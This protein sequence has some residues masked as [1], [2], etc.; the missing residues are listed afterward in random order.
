VITRRR[1]PTYPATPAGQARRLRDSED[2]YLAGLGHDMTWRVG[3]GARWLK[4]DPGYRGT[5]GLCGGVARLAWLGD[6]VGYH[7]YEGA[8]AKKMFSGPRKC[9]RGR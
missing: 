6:G 5:C 3:H 9:T 7:G 1:K 4:G 8:M 2:A